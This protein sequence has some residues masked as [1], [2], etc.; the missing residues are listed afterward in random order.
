M[1]NIDVRDVTLHSGDREIISGASF[2]LT[3]GIV[4]ALV[5]GSGSGWTV[6]ALPLLGQARPGSVVSGMVATATC[7]R[8]AAHP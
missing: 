5:G 6:I 3:S 8:P 4:T 7:H 1:S 2:S